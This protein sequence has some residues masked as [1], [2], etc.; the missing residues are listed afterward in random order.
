LPELIVWNEGTIKVKRENLL[1]FEQKDFEDYK[2]KYNEYLPEWA[3][4]IKKVYLFKNKLEKIDLFL[5]NINAMGKMFEIVD[6]YTANCPQSKNK[7]IPAQ[8]AIFPENDDKDNPDVNSSINSKE[9]NEDRKERD[10]E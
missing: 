5:L 3:K 2:Q 6:D 1:Y 7:E 4:V 10:I 8:L 9:T